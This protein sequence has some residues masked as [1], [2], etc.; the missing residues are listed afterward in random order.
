MRPG[1]GKK[2]PVGTRLEVRGYLLLIELQPG[3]IEWEPQSP[4]G[5]HQTPPALGE[6]HRERETHTALD[7]QPTTKP[8]KC[9]CLCVCELD[10]CAYLSESRENLICHVFK[11]RK[12]CINGTY[13][14][15]NVMQ[16]SNDFLQCFSTHQCT[17]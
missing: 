13:Q 4:T 10:V 2:S 1:G 15:V 3:G 17:V 16:H 5:V 11:C 7:Q 8:T 9:L 6:R 12:L 14:H